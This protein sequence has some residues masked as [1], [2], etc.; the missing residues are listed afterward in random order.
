MI[1]TQSDVDEHFAMPIPVFADFGTGMVRLGQVGIAGNT[2]RNVDILLPSQ[3]KKVASTPTKKS[4][5]AN[6]SL[7]WDAE[8]NQIRKRQPRSGE[9]MQPTACL[10][11]PKGREPWSPHVTEQ[12]PEGAKE[13]PVTAAPTHQ[14][15]QNRKA[16]HSPPPTS[17]AENIP[18]YSSRDTK[19]AGQP[20]QGK[21]HSP[22]YDY[23]HPSHH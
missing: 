3:P 19:V 18:S 1:I 8:L 2:T 12:S 16:P 9:R 6:R 21:V 22:H 14:I 17:P 11:L 15:Q 7:V 5:N 20:S 4:W 23:H 13:I 10:S